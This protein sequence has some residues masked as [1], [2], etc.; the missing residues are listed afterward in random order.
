M[1]KAIIL[2]AAAA[3][4]TCYLIYAY[5][6]FDGRSKV[7][8]PI[9]LSISA[10]LPE[11]TQLE[12]VYK[13]VKDPTQTY[14]IKPLL[15]DTIPENTYLF[16][17]DTSQQVLNLSIYFLSLPLDE[18][19]HLQQIIASN[20]RGAEFKFSLLNRDLMASEN[21]RLDQIDAHSV[22]IRRIEYPAP[23][24]P[25][26]HFDV[27]DSFKTIA[28]YSQLKHPVRPSFPGA[29][30]IALMGVLMALLLGPVFQQINRKGISI[31]AYILG[32]VIF[33]LPT[34]EKVCNLLLALS[35][36]AGFYSILTKDSFRSWMKGNRALLYVTAAMVVLFLA[37]Y[38]LSLG[39]SSGK[40][41]MVVKFGLP[42]T[43]LAVSVSAR[44]LNELQFHCTALVAGVVLSV[45]LH[46][47]WLILFYDSV[48]DK[49]ELIAQPRYY[50]EANVFS[51]VH[52]SYLSAL[53]LFGIILLFLGKDL[54]SLNRQQRISLAVL[55]LLALLFAFSRAA[56]LS[57]ALILLYLAGKWIARYLHMEITQFARYAIASILSIALVFGVLFYPKVDAS[58][59]SSSL[60]G[61]QTR[62]VLWGNASEIIR[63]KP[64][65]GWGPGK[66]QA[67]L[68]QSNMRNIYNSNSGLILNTHNQFLET[69]GTFGLLAALALIWFLL[70]P[71]GF[72]KE[73]SRYRDMVFCTALVFISLFLFESFLNRNL[74]ILTM[75]ICYGLV[76]KFRYTLPA[77]SDLRK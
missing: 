8:E 21:L 64:I 35:I 71:G 73:S 18:D 56:I 42:M 36:P 26:L 72:L 30:V 40:K 41:L 66:Y 14:R 76:M 34:G 62:T 45:F 29:L 67:A 5:N 25:A 48:A 3:L 59:R 69:A 4:Y 24:S 52:H 70:F 19:C 27:K 32:L 46:I 23:L 47:G 28:V 75:G 12:L 50:L 2:L 43:L 37:A 54:L 7:F 31:G 60:R 15:N 74:G 16:N 68:T 51:I 63:D 11:N 38:L 22:S 49:A 55:I 10:D 1:K 6:V 13:T 58:I 39:D 53:Y 77:F 20:N 61:L 17:I 57:L 44:K 9:R 33:I 65:T